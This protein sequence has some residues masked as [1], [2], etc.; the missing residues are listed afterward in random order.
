MNLEKLLNCG[1]LIVFD[2]E[3]TGLDP[4]KCQII[5]LAAIKVETRNGLPE[6]TAEMD[7]FINL[8]KG[9]TL[10]P[11]IVELTGITDDLLNQKGVDPETAATVFVDL[12]EPE[13]NPILIAHNAQFDACFLRE[14]LKGYSL[15][16][17]KW[18]D[19]LTVCRDR[20][21]YPHKLEAMIERYQLKGV[22]NSHRAIDD[23]HALYALLK[24]LDEER[25]DLDRYINLF[26]VNPKYGRSG[27]PIRGVTYINQNCSR[28]N[29]PLAPVGARLFEIERRRW[30]G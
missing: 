8:P 6:I 25:G 26:G 24:A 28:N 13:I 30:E 9:E 12:I 10:P 23:V 29:P 5:E 3:T 7:A 27:A 15:S 19:T 16:P 22:Q 2:T 4:E 21:F 14:L 11:R 1:S 18:L 17:V 20:T